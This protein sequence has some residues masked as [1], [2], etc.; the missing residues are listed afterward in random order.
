MPDYQEI[1]LTTFE[2]FLVRDGA[3]EKTRKN[4]KSDLRQF[5]L[6]LQNSGEA[7]THESFDSEKEL[8][9]FVSPE[10]LEN[11]KR[12][13]LLANVPTATINRRLSTLRIFF[14]CAVLQGW[15]TDDPTRLILNI[16]KAKLSPKNE[17]LDEM[18]AAFEENM[19]KNNT[20][21][22]EGDRKDLLDFFNWFSGNQASHV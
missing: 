14:R 4:Y 8:L 10:R 7:A 9:S 22:S 2:D 5:L 6:W 3:S 11:Y 20:P 18:I 1:L 13:Q 16:P 19:R 12:S 15:V 17:S 21:W